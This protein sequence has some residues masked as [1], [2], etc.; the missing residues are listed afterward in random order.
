MASYPS[1]DPHNRGGEQ[2]EKKGCYDPVDSCIEA[3]CPESSGGISRGKD[4]VD[5][6][7]ETDLRLFSTSQ[8]GCDRTGPAEHGS[9]SEKCEEANH[10]GVGQLIP[11]TA[12]I[13]LGA[14]HAG[15]RSATMTPDTR[16]ISRNSAFPSAT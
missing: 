8:K 4:H 11:K 6:T 16:P 10:E 15:N 5:A 2:T 9:D 13:R 7:G 3:G 1:P 12:A 14:G